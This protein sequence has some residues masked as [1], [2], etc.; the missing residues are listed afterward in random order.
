MDLDALW[1]LEAMVLAAS[2]GTGLFLVD[3]EWG[4]PPGLTIRE[5]QRPRRTDAPGPFSSGPSD[6]ERD[7]KSRPRDHKLTLPLAPQATST[8]IILLSGGIESTTLL[9]EARAQGALRALFLDYG[10]SAALQER[11]AAAAACARTDTPL[12]VIHLKRLAADLAGSTVIRPHVPLRARNLLAVSIAANWA[13]KT[14]ARRIL[15]GLQREDRKHPEGQPDFI[16]PLSECLA[17]LK[18]V[19]EIPY[20]EL[21]KADVMARGLT[22]GVDYALT[23]SCLLGH[24]APCGQC[25]QC[26]A[27]ASALLALEDPSGPPK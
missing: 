9:Y 17:S 16:R 7:L 10:Q 11:R 13:L 6:P 14:Q 27:R 22:L 18:L 1:R 2:D 21:S 8:D 25:S 24:R 12:T 23:Y 5:R 3:R 19:L 4:A 20:R 26:H 15:L